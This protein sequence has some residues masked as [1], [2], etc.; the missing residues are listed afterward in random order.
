M[1]RATISLP[2]PLSPVMSTLASE[3]AT[4]SISCC[5][6]TVAGLR[7]ISWMCVFDRTAAIEPMRGMPSMVVVIAS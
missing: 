3:R 2:T 6:A 4:R 1:V 5:S 7:P